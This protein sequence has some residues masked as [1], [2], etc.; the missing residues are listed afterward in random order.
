MACIRHPRNAF[1]YVAICIPVR[2]DY[3]TAV[4]RL[5]FCYRRNRNEAMK[6]RLKCEDPNQIVYTVTT[7]ATAA[8]WGHFRDCLDD[9][10]MKS[11]LPHRDL[12]YGFRNQINDL[13]AQARKIYWTADSP[14]DGG[15]ERG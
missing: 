5:D 11:L 10:V 14:S 9:F 13:L 7:T 6:M 4:A 3:R 8:E 15:G 12:V 1:A 2:S